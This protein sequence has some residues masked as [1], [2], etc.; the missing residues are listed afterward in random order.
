MIRIGGG[1][2]EGSPDVAAGL[3]GP[4]GQNAQ[5]LEL[6]GTMQEGFGFVMP[7]IIHD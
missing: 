2:P 5:V 6:L 7:F 1:R 3:C 4:A